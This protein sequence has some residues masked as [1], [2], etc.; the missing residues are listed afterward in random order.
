MNN[1]KLLA[2][3]AISV[4]VF[5]G[6][7]TRL[8]SIR[9][10]FLLISISFLFTLLT[11]TFYFFFINKFT[12]FDPKTIKIK[13]ILLGPLGYFVYFLGIVQSQRSFGSV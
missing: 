2:M 11:F 1:P 6:Y 5:G 7:L 10:E 8:L 12:V 9:S 13:F 3:F 4:F